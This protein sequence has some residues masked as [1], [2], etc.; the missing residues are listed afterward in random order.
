MDLHLAKAVRYYLQQKEKVEHAAASSR[1]RL[2]ALQIPVNNGWY[3]F[4][5][6]DSATFYKVVASVNEEL[7]SVYDGAASF[8]L[9]RWTLGKHGANG[10]APLSSCFYAYQSADQAALAKFPKNSKHRASPKVIIEVTASGKAYFNPET[11]MWALPRVRTVR[12]V[13]YTIPTVSD[14]GSSDGPTEQPSPGR[15]P[16]MANLDAKAT[17]WVP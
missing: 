12:I 4:D 3:P 11:N 17:P 9:G 6:E 16:S 2:L 13:P 10:W 8:S 15:T 5:I 1:Q 7:V 14:A